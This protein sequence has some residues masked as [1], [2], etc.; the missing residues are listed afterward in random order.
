MI[1]IYVHILHLHDTTIATVRVCM[2]RTPPQG[3][4]LYSPECTLLQDIIQTNPKLL[5]IIHS[6]KVISNVRILLF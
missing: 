5:V 3:T 1:L 4:L 2:Y 6:E